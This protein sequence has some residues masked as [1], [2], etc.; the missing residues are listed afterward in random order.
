MST[1]ILAISEPPADCPIDKDVLAPRLL[2]GET[3]QAFMTMKYISPSVKASRFS[4]TVNPLQ[5]RDEL[6]ETIS[7]DVH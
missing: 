5:L 6:Y 4:R 2:A 7:D 3:V 1:P